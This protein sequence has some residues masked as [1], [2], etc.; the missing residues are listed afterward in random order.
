MRRTIATPRNHFKKSIIG[1]NKP[2]PIG[3]KN[4]GRPDSTDPGIDDRQ[5][6]RLFRKFAGICRQQICRRLWGVSGSIGEQV[7][8]RNPWR[9]LVKHGLHLPLIG[10]SDAEIGVKND[11]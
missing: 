4:A 10:T 11:H 3:F 5:K 8:D 6:H 7:N 9:F 2:T 1:A